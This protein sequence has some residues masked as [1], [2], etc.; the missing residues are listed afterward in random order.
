MTEQ[1]RR[2]LGQRFPHWGLR[3]PTG[4]G[5]EVDNNK[6]EFSTELFKI[7]FTEP[8]SSRVEHK[9]VIAFFW[10]SRST[11]FKIQTV[12]IDRCAADQFSVRFWLLKW[13]RRDGFS[14]EDS[15]LCRGLQSVSGRKSIN[16]TAD[17]FHLAVFKG[18]TRRVACFWISCP[19]D[20]RRFNQLQRSR[21]LLLVLFSAHGDVFKPTN[22]L[23]PH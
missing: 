2:H 16:Q 12:L 22:S 9:S 15:P 11:L 20:R 4:V 13:T 5:L 14:R 7:P 3:R 10:Q 17:T 18:C 23:L 21:W 8:T 1:P 19:F 6:F